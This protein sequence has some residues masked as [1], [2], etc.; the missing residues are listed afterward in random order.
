MFMDT[1]DDRSS[2]PQEDINNSPYPTEAFANPIE[3]AKKLSA[4][5]MSQIG[6]AFG[7]ISVSMAHQFA[8]HLSALR[9]IIGMQNEELRLFRTMEIMV[10]AD[11]ESANKMLHVIAEWRQSLLPQE[12]KAASVGVGERVDSI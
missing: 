11:D 6:D 10:Y 8:K 2:Q 1:T 12:D 5:Q 3:Y 9:A 7:E 4:D